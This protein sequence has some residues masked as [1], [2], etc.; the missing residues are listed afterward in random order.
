[1]NYFVAK[2][3]SSTTIKM[4]HVAIVKEI[5]IIHTYSKILLKLNGN[6]LYQSL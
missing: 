1:M 4:L 2:R 3:N 5:V 6:I